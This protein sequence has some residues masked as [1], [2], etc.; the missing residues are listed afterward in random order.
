MIEFGD[1]IYYIDLTVFDETVMVKK[2]TESFIQLDKKYVLDED[3]KIIQTEILESVRERP[4]EIEAVKYDII[5]EMLMVI[6]DYDGGESD[7]TALGAER[8]LTKTPLSY[9]IA[10]NT[11][12]NY[13]I[14]K[15]KE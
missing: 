7:D 1:S 11:L 15:E 8:A 4:K 3:G 10:F 6:L 14:L 13:G 5:R 2:P 12:L 9:Q